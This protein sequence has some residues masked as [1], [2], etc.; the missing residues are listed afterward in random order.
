MF[1]TKPDGG[2]CAID[3]PIPAKDKEED[4]GVGIQYAHAHIGSLS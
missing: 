2:Q 1:Q 4:N 3:D